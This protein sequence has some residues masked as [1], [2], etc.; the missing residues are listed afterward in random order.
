[1]ILHA[2]HDQRTLRRSVCHV[3]EVCIDAHNRGVILNISV[4]CLRS[5]HLI[6]HA[7]HAPRRC[8][9]VLVVCI[10]LH[11]VASDIHCCRV[12]DDLFVVRRQGVRDVLLHTGSKGRILAGEDGIIGVARLTAN[13]V[14]CQL[15]EVVGKGVA[16]GGA[17]V[18]EIRQAAVSLQQGNCGI[19]RICRVNRR[20]KGAL[21]LAVRKA[22]LSEVGR[23]VR[24]RQR[25]GEI[26]LHQRTD[27]LAAGQLGDEVVGVH[28][29][30]EVHDAEGR[31]LIII[32]AK[33]VVQNF[34]GHGF[35]FGGGQLAVGVLHQI[36]D[37]TGPAAI[38]QCG[39]G[40]AVIV[41]QIHRG[42]HVRELHL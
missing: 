24:V 37:V 28:I 8:V 39:Y 19:S 9:V 42:E 27:R 2:L 31:V 38:V 30:A 17:Q 23:T 5:R 10:N 7:G 32:N 41:G 21:C 11:I 14:T 35:H 22:V 4:I 3:V 25:A 15:P 20:T 1:M 29:A 6:S 26:A 12:I 34:L 13:L 36:N 18:A 33:V 16:A 40:L